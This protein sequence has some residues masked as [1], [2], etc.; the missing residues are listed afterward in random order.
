MRD[1]NTSLVFYLPRR[2]PCAK[3]IAGNHLGAV[4]GI[5]SLLLQQLGDGLEAQ[6]EA[7]KN[8]TTH[9]MPGAKAEDAFPDFIA[10]KGR[11]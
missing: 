2:T 1:L 4:T 11:G 8:Y 5:K 10:R 3:M 7:E 6:W 9:V